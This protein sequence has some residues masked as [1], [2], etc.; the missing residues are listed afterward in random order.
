MLLR[1]R[2]SYQYLLCKYQQDYRLIVLDLYLREQCLRNHLQMNLLCFFQ[3]S[4]YLLR[5]IVLLFLTDCHILP[6]LQ[7]LIQL[8]QSLVEHHKYHKRLSSA[9]LFLLTRLKSGPSYRYWRQL[10]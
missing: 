6:S 10:R 8:D 7:R 5:Q 2:L 1:R 3:R 4:L 9:L